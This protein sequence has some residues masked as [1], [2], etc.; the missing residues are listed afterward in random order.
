M[1]LGFAFSFIAFPGFLI[2]LTENHNIDVR[3][4]WLRA[5]FGEYD[6]H[7]HVH[8]EFMNPW[9]TKIG[10]REWSLVY[11]HILWS[12]I[13]FA[14]KGAAAIIGG[15][16]IALFYLIIGSIWLTMKFLY[17]HERW[18]PSVSGILGGLVTYTWLMVTHDSVTTIG[19]LALG[20]FTLLAW[21]G[22]ASLTSGAL[23]YPVAELISALKWFDTFGDGLF[24]QPTEESPPTS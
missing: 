19:P 1:M 15:G 16:C 17:S 14:A 3:Y 8:M 20:P 9:S 10:W 24:S 6:E 18:I 13:V 4:T 11:G 2:Q 7:D 23:A 12:F 22:I 5:V 21:T